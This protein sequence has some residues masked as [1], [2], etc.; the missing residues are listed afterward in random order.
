VAATADH[1]TD[2]FNDSGL[3]GTDEVRFTSAVANSTLSLYAGDLGI[4]KVVIGT[5]TA[6]AAVSTA[7]TALNVNASAL[8]YGITLV[9]NAGANALTGGTGN[10]T[11]Q[12]GAGN[13]V[14]NGGNGFDYADYTSATKVITVNLGLITA[15]NTGGAG[16]D[17]LTGIEGM[18]GGSAADTLTGDA[19]A[20]ILIGNAGNDALNGAAG[21]DQLKGGNGNDV[22]TGGAGIDWFIF[23][24]AAN[25]TTNK[26]TISDFVSGVDVLQFSRAI[27]T[28]MSAASLGAL[29]ID[30]FWSGSNATAAH[31]A[32]DRLIYNNTTGALY[33]DAD[34]TGTGAAI[35][36]ALL[37][38]T[39]HP[40]LTYIDFVIV[41]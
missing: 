13:D 18:L 16:T 8:T 36:V 14:L 21:F 10:D 9:G 26:D 12:G 34:G 3:V 25:A 33:Y 20:N 28:G 6:S 19:N 40:A 7:T 41:G 24:V 23:D 11:L 38:T 30:A 39:T 2:E 17:T 5:G 27:F 29:S 15:Q 1:G 35:Q 22:L 37:G 31:D 32:T 4:D